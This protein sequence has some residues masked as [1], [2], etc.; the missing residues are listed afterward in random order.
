V[1]VLPNLMQKP[2]TFTQRFADFFNTQT[3]IFIIFGLLGM[4]AMKLMGF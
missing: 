1:A 4:I 3:L 2:P